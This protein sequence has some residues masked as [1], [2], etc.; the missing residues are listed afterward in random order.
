MLEEIQSQA[1]E[2]ARGN[3]QT[4]GENNDYYITLEQLE[5]ILKSF[6]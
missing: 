4:D 1:I 3:K 6:E 2:I 5:A